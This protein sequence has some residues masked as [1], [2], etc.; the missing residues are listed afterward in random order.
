MLIQT[1]RFGAVEITQSDVITLT[2]GILGF[3][4]LTK[5]VL[6]D[7]PKDEIFA[8]LQSCEN[9]ALAFPVLEPELFLAGYKVQLSKAEAQSLGITEGVVPRYYTIVTIPDDPAQMTANLKAPVVINVKTRLGKQVIAK[10]NDYQI[11]FPI[12]AELQKRLVQNPTAPMK[13]ST[14]A[15]VKIGD[16]VGAPAPAADGAKA[17]TKPINA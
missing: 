15:S 13:S 12:F 10:E 7:D 3:P 17:A 2:E 4:D 8:W 5:Y 14:D 16:S 9:P 1:T 6:I 11:K